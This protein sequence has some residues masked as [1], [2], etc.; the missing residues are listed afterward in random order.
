MKCYAIGEINFSDHHWVNDYLKN[1][2]PLVKKLGGIYLARTPSVELL[3]G[4]GGGSPNGRS[5]SIS[6]KRSGDEVLP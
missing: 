5:Y 4:E 2:T 1:V 6:F 3:E